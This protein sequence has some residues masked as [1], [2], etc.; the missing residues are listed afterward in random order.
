M[1][2]G[3]AYVLKKVSVEKFIVPNTTEKEQS[4]F[5]NKVKIIEEK[6]ATFQSLQNN[7]ISL[8]KSKFLLNGSTNKLNRWSKYDFATFLKELEKT[9]K[10]TAKENETEYKKLSL[11]EEAE[12]MQYFNEQKQKALELKN[13]IDKTN[14]EIDQ[15]VYELY[16]LTK[17]EI[18][19]VEEATT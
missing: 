8:V 9:R 16:G 6:T 11:S 5:C 12:W 17:D 19:I 18:K 10:D 14:R 2:A 13:E 3:G 1:T 4:D 7:Y 15:M